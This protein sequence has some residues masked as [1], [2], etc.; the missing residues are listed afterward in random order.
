MKRKTLM[1]VMACVVSVCMM[2]MLLF[3]ACTPT[4]KLSVTLDKT[5]ESIYV[6]DSFKLEA[7]VEG[8]TDETLSWATSD[9]KVATIRNGTV[10]GVGAG[11]ATITAKIGEA[12]ATCTVTVTAIDVTISKS[13]ATIEK[14]ATLSLS[15][16]ASDNG[17]ITW[18]TSDSSIAT[19]NGEGLVTAV[20]E[21]KATITAKRGGAGSASC[22]V[23][24]TWANKPSDYV[25]IEAG[26]EAGAAGN[27][28]TWIYWADQGWVQATVNVSTAEYA[29]GEAT[30]SYTGNTGAWFGMQIF[31][32]STETVIDTRYN[33]TC[34]ITSA[35]AGNITINGTVVAL[36]EGKNEIS[37]YYTE[38]ANNVNNVPAASL[39]LQCGV[40][41]TGELM[42]ENTLSIANLKFTAAEAIALTTPTA[43]SI[44]Q[45]KTVTVTH[46]NGD[47]A[48]SFMLLFCN[49]Q[50]VTVYQQAVANGGK[51]DDS[52]M[53]DGTYSVK[54]FAI[55]EGAYSNSEV[56][57]VL[58][59]YRV[60]NGGISYDIPNGGETVAV[61][62]TGRYYYWTEFA[63]IEN[64]KYDN[65][66]VTLDIVNGGNWYSNQLF[67]K[68][69]ALQAGKTYTLTFKITTTAAGHITV[70]GQVIELKEG[71]NEVRITYAELG[72]NTASLS[73]QFG[74]NEGS[75][76]DITS[77]TITISD[78]AWNA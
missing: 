14:G 60:A 67:M 54:A 50:G 53:N 18:E 11:T 13:E 38:T 30:F 64:A 70:N 7:T 40:S 8:E 76:V 57:G 66:T 17:A 6:G 68:N 23:T 61:A 32:K 49:D 56:S 62:N 77:A 2:A 37:V 33:L 75:V 72:A 78:I 73:I 35:K 31:Y 43:L 34:T 47:N 58:A 3:T 39:S 24:V 65:G 21:G 20:A 16:T 9:D 36:K 29:N 12:S 1:S 59:S 4:A 48:T 45:D 51:I 19:V 10:R 15:A 22:Q 44:A 26:D 25:L 69:S 55:G 46:G 5:E 63:G 42:E 27:P 41:A 52:T 71:V 74:V 28:G